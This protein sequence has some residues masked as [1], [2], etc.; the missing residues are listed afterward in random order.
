MTTEQFL[1]NSETSVYYSRA[2]LLHSRMLTKNRI[3]SFSYQLRPEIMIR[4]DTHSPF[5]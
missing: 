3:E 1:D 5:Q 2:I 4:P